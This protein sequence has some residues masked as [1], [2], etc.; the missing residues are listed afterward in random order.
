MP[1]PPPVMRA[2]LPD[3]ERGEGGEHAEIVRSGIAL[4]SEL[5]FQIPSPTEL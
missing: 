2:R 3:I 5:S 1:D 4:F